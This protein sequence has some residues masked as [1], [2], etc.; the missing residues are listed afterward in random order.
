MIQNSIAATPA[1]QALE[2]HQKRFAGTSTLDLFEADPQRFSSFSLQAAGLLFDF[3]KQTLK[4]ET[5]RLLLDLAQAAE[6]Q[7]R[8]A[9]LFSGGLV[10]DSEQRPALHTALRDP[11]SDPLWV[12]DLDLKAAIAAQH[13]RMAVLSHDLRQGQYRGATGSAI[14]EVLCL[15]IGGSALGPRMVSEAL[16]PYIDTAIRCHFLSNVDS[17]SLART[18]KQL[19]PEK[20]LCLIS[21][22]T[23]STPE[24]MLNAH[25]VRQWLQEALGTD[26]EQHLI[27]IT[28]N[29][30]AA[31]AFGLPDRQIFEFWD[32][33][34]GRYSIWSAVGLPLAILMGWSN[35]SD[36]LSGAHAM[37]LHVRSAP[38][39]QNMPVLM[40]LIGVWNINFLQQQTQ[41]I[42][43]YADGL[44][45]LPAYL[46]QLE[47]ESNGKLGHTVL[48]E[49]QQHQMATA[50]VIW[51]GVGCD[52]QHAYMQCLHQ[53]DRQVPIDFL[54]A[55]QGDPHFQ[56]QHDYLVASC[57]AQSQA[58]MEGTLRNAAIRPG[59]PR[60]CPGN[61]PSSTLLYPRLSPAVLG[62]LIALYEHKVF[63]QGV[64][65]QIN[66]F[67]Q[68]GV[69]LGK[70]L[71]QDMLP[72]L[73]SEHSENI[74]EDSKEQEVGKAHAVDGST[75]GLLAYVRAHR[76]V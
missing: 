21:S 12:G 53:S 54:V 39:S 41:A 15:G 32:C 72:K 20:T 31:R 18:L 52:A 1:W 37:D 11:S 60:Y 44:Q 33:I 26:I 69:E 17:H 5:L 43:P 75:Q 4:P 49:G 34:G 7:V 73:C 45:L 29:P 6:V 70:K 36:F 62:A 19:S 76:V 63:V 56:A 42:I 14:E 30:K 2:K 10:N 71:V 66:S 8:I 28:A 25:R 40:A 61:R 38:L 68:W 51:G 24:T 3:S 59:D 67:D 55:A 74:A 64:I 13:Q 57:V 22:K 47:M 9:D 27:A 16:A 50:P 58:L 35:F 65:W 46:Q 23:F 48:F